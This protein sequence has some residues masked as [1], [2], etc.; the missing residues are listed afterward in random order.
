MAR[1]VATPSIPLST[2]RVAPARLE[3]PA[4]REGA[5]VVSSVVLVLLSL[6]A[7]A[8]IGRVIG[9]TLYPFDLDQ[10]EGYDVNSG[11]LLTQGRSIYTSNE[12]WPYYSSNYPP[13]F[14]VMLTPLITMLG[15][16]LAAGRLLSATAALL[17]A[18]LIGVAVIR[19]RG[20][21]IAAAIAGLLYL[22]SPYV[23]HTTPLARVN[24]LAELF[25]LAGV[26]LCFSRGRAAYACGAV[27]LAV[28]VFT[29]PTAAPVLAAAFG[30]GLITRPR[31]A[32]PV[33]VVTGMAGLLVLAALERISGGAFWLNTVQGNINPWGWGQATSYWTNFS[34]IHAG[35]IGVV[36][37][38]G[39]RSASNRYWLY[40]LACLPTVI[41]VGK[42]GAGESYFLGLIV[43]LCVLVGSALSAL[44]IRPT[45]L[46]VASLTLLVQCGLYLHE[47]FTRTVGLSAD[48]GI[49]FEALG[50]TPRADDAL[51][52]W[53]LIT[54]LDDNPG[55]VLA[56]DA[57]YALLSGR[58]IVGNATHLRNL[59]ASGH[60][61][62]ERLLA[63]IEARRFNW[64]VLDAQLYPEPVLQTIGHT[65][66][67]YEVVQHRGVEQWI[68]APGADPDAQEESP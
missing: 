16:T 59:H 27:L 12:E 8:Y 50:T 57:T 28:A 25:S 23:Y 63:D 61:Q 31:F 11:W 51:P 58:E 41:G 66:Y 22:A 4:A 10:G 5:R 62:G 43:A 7:V 52:G 2:I 40:A 42:W 44:S 45:G 46:L 3:S 6:Y 30:Y 68:F 9:L 48:L 15:P 55:P 34:L 29:K 1:T 35:L 32:V 26:I 13:V 67:L 36:L 56:E 21:I 19:E 49:Q 65:Y 38:A 24:A 54:I 64:I 60:W 33:M 47:P 20:T 37:L 53:D 14:S 18:L 39:R 17:T